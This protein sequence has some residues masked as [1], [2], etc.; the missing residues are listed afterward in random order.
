MVRA[1]RS[2]IVSVCVVA[3]AVIVACCCDCDGIW[4]GRLVKP[5]DGAEFGANG[6]RAP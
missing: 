2:A 6:E 4:E 3:G 5:V 1:A